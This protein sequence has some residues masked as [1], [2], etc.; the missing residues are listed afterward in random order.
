MRLHLLL[1]QVNPEK[2]TAPSHCP[3]PNCSGKKFRLHQPVSKTVR[4]TV[5]QQVEAHRYHCLKGKR[6]FRVYPEG[7]SGAHTSGRVKG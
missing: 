3:F 2:I 6:T 5:Y 1:P 4:D 7:V